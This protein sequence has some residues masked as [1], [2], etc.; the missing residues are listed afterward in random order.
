M[1]KKITLEGLDHFKDKENAMI[2]GKPE[3][4]NT[5]TVAHAVGEYF[6]WKGVLHIV[7]AA[8]A[9]GGTIQTNT[10]V[11]PAVLADDVS[12][13]KES[14]T[15]NIFTPY[16]YASWGVSGYWKISSSTTT[17]VSDTPTAS[18]TEGQKCIQIPVSVGD[19]FTLAIGTS[20]NS[21]LRAWN[22]IKSDRTLIE[23]ATGTPTFDSRSNPIEL[24]I[25]DNDAAYLLI[26]YNN[27]TYSGGY[28]Y[29]DSALNPLREVSEEVIEK[30]ITI[31][32]NLKSK[33]VQSGAITGTT[34]G[35]TMEYTVNSDSSFRNL[36]VNCKKGDKFIITGSGGNNARLWVFVDTSDKILSVESAS[37]TRTNLEVIAPSD[38]RAI[39]N[40]NVNNSRPYELTY[41]HNQ[42]MPEVEKYDINSIKYVFGTWN[43]YEPFEDMTGWTSAWGTA[44]FPTYYNLFHTL[45]QQHSDVVGFEEIDMSIDYLADP[46]VTDS[47]PSEISGINN[48]KL[49]MYHI[50]PLPNSFEMT[51]QAYKVPKIMIVSG[52]HGGEKKSIIDCYILLKKL[53]ENDATSRAITLLRMCDIYIAPMINVYGINENTRVNYNDVNLNRDFPVLEW[54]Q[55]D[56]GGNTQ[57]LSQYETRCLTWW[58]NTIAP[59]ALVDH[60]TSSGNISTE[61]NR[62]LHWGASLFDAVASI[63]NQN[64]MEL[65]P[66]YRAKFSTEL[67]DYQFAMGYAEIEATQ[68]KGNLETF[69]CQKGISAI[70]YEVMMHLKWDAE[71]EY[72]WGFSDAD[73]NTLVGIAWHGFINMLMTLTSNTVKWLNNGTSIKALNGFTD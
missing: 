17:P 39:F 69:A 4:T 55:S 7:T 6:Y 10:N 29:K 42:T 56:D 24:K 26:N 32:E 11:K 35:S 63:I 49:I 68:Y 50:P 33:I 34:I 44:D 48:G 2:A 57:P 19:V 22:L 53:L 70:T 23:R 46:D 59:D 64:E 67:A 60:H 9:V 27:K 3:S 15:E 65:T 12:D 25:S 14:I 52:L 51:L 21:N 43:G 16:N 36:V 13:L 62:S 40:F 38:G 45:A 20:Q 37:I 71:G 47:I 41:I 73:E 66:Y 72:I 61:T 5:A 30:Y 28:I 31:R 18:S 54:T 1:S 8:I 58:I